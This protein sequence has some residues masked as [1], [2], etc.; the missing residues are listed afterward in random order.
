MKFFKHGG[1][2]NHLSEGHSLIQKVETHFGTTID[3][4]DRFLRS[5]LYKCDMLSDKIAQKFNSLELNTNIDGKRV[6]TA[7][8]S[9][10]DYFLPSGHMQT[11]LETS[12]TPTMHIVL[13]MLE[14]LKQQIKYL[15]EDLVAIEKS[16]IHSYIRHLA[17]IFL[18]ELNA[19][20]I[21]DLWLAG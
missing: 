13:V 7:L 21:H 12:K 10:C 4:V 16:S 9:I 1:K 11:N 19:I 14:Q 20:P 6:Q 17:T 8:Q 5:V 2:N 3:V 15:I 18:H